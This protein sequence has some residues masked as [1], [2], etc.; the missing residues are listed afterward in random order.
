[1]CGIVGFI[2]RSQCGR[3]NELVV[4]MANS[5]EH[6]GPDDL[7]TW[8]DENLGL[9]LGHR[10]LSIL[11]LSDAGHQP[12]ASS[13]GQYVLVFNGEIYNHLSI[14]KELHRCF[15]SISWRGHSDTETLLC[16][17]SC[18]GIEKTLSKINSIF[19]PTVNCSS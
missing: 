17:F 9:A 8:I 7:G 4:V 11:D 18:W 16:G 14:R 10:R 3:L 6:R 5:L 12:M 19:C 2:N 1:L 13:C 15:P